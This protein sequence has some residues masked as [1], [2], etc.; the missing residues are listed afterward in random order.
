MHVFVLWH[1]F[2][3][4]FGKTQQEETRITD[5]QELLPKPLVGKLHKERQLER[6]TEGKMRVYVAGKSSLQQWRRNKLQRAVCRLGFW[7]DDLFGIRPI[8]RMSDCMKLSQS[9]HTHRQHSSDLHHPEY[10][11]SGHALLLTLRVFVCLFVC[12][13]EKQKV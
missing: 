8:Y 2:L 7:K 5:C 6:E 1:S 11:K 12:V 9:T 4:R 3:Y 10:D 13:T